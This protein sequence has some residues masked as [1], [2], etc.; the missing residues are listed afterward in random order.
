MNLNAPG[1]A[2]AYHTGPFGLSSGAGAPSEQ[3]NAS[4]W[5]D[6]SMLW[7]SYAVQDSQIYSPYSQCDDSL[8]NADVVECFVGPA[9]TV[10][11]T[12]L[13]KYIEI[14]VSPFD[15][16]FVSNVTNSNGQ[17]SGIVGD[18]LDCAS[19]GIYH[20]TKLCNTT[21]ECSG[22]VG[23]R[24]QLGIPWS[25]LMTFFPGQPAVPLNWRVN[26][27]R[28]DHW[29]SPPLPTQ[30]QAWS[31]DFASP[32]CFHMPAYFGYVNLPSSPIPKR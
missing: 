22:L 19:T 13:S 5:Y 18:L 17:C 24:V 4:I 26:L 16:L 7:V 31:P 29:V 8:Y 10:S 20:D 30:Y 27:F 32:A 11:A 25:L 3:T 14:E 23:Y 6:S 21:S 15:V 12:G 1:A 28:I 9:S 2:A